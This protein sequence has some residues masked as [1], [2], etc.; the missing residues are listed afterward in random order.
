MRV[1]GG[2]VVRDTNF[3]GGIEGGMTN[4]ETVVVHLF[5][6]PI[7]TAQR[8]ARTFDM[9]TNQSADS[10]YVRSDVCVI[11]ALA[12]IAE[13][14]AA[15]EILD[16]LLDKFGGDHIDDTLAAHARYIRSLEERFRK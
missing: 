5:A 14:V 16:T 3:A 7:P 4:G 11:P 6:K 9:K 10:P 12:V 1:E 13:S 2:R 15:W 8:R